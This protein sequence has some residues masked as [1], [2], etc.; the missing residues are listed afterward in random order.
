MQQDERTLTMVF[1]ILPRADWD[2]A[3]REGVYRGSAADH[4]DGFIH[5]STRDQIDGTL[6]RHFA[7]QV[8]LVLVA[9]D[10]RALGE[11]L[12]YEPARDGQLFPHLYGELPTHLAIDVTQI[13][14][15]A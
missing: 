15:D 14:S 11:A 13:A 3:L 8:G 9:V 12:K 6:A 10:A 2:A 4:R 7:G 1:K 5:F